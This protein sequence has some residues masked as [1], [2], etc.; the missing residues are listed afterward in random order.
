MPD[1]SSP[2]S[3]LRGIRLGL[4]RGLVAAAVVLVLPAGAGLAMAMTSGRSHVTPTAQVLAATKSGHLVSVSIRIA[5]P[6]PAGATGTTA[7]AGKITFHA[8]STKAKWSGMPTSKLGQCVLTLHLK[9][10]VSQY[11]KLKLFK[12]TFSGSPRVAPFT[13]TLHI[14]ILTPHTPSAPGSPTP[15]PGSPSPGGPASGGTGS[16]GTSTTPT[17][18]TGSPCSAAPAELEGTWVSDAPQP[19]GDSPTF[20]FRMYVSHGQVTGAQLVNP[21][22][23]EC[24]PIGGEYHFWDEPPTAAF[25]IGSSGQFAGKFE[26]TEGGVSKYEITGQLDAAALRG[27]VVLKVT[28]SS[29]NMGEMLGAIHHI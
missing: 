27:T 18:C 15:A 29:C 22:D 21:E 25:E 13:R 20:Y 12:V 24:K 1:P 14:S 9:L 6:I 16:T 17:G 7:C 26:Y 23:F 3:W 28:D 5:Y 2:G 11:G 10:P 8:A 4:R 19:P